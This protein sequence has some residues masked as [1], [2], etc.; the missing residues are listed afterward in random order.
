MIKEYVGTGTNIRKEVMPSGLTIYFLPLENRNNYYFD[1]MTNYGS[2][3][4][5]YKFENEKKYSKM[6]YGIAHFLEHKLFEQED[7]MDPFEYFSKYGIDSNA[8]T[9]YD[10]TC[11]YIE[12]TK[13]QKE[14][15]DFLLKFVNTP[16]FTD[17]NVE[18][19]KGIIIQE[20][21]MYRD[22]PFD[23]LF[24]TSMEC[25]FKNSEARIDIG[26][27]PQSVTKITKEDL[28]R[29]YEAFYRPKNMTLFVG[30]NY[31]YN[32]VMKV[33]YDN[34]KVIEKDN[35]FDVEIK[36]EIES[37]DVNV[38]YKE[39]VIN[40]L[41][42]PKMIYSIKESVSGYSVKD[43]FIYEFIIDF[44]LDNVYS[45][46]SDF[47]KECIKN[48]LFNNFEYESNILDDFMLIQMACESK[49]P[50][51][52]IP[53][54]K[55]YYDKNIITEE[56]LERYKKVRIA[57]EVKRF[58]YVVPSINELKHDVISYGDILYN[59]IDLIKSI[60]LKQVKK[61]KNEID[62][63]NVSIVVGKIN[64]KSS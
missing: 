6:P 38:K 30:G 37:Y 35:I 56:D 29:C 33:L 42:I 54:I 9:S 48:K 14:G 57:K 43:K 41:A 22:D 63:D 23:K 44:L 24:R 2:L 39:L 12:G 10:S 47:Y 1:Y 45:E 36:R 32:E 28:Y 20:L 13:Y 58:D 60:N 5:T 3:I 59:K 4:N 15:L 40:G 61:V 11:Y 46:T 62:F 31:D 19:E 52:I 21:N 27:S 8:A 7:G 50:K 51:K 18:K 25:I 26:G 16:Y 34:D 55:E 64:K 49:N 17:K 53:M